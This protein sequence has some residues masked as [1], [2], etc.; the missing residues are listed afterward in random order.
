MT[1]IVDKA[2][3]AVTG[4]DLIGAIQVVTTPFTIT[5]LVTLLITWLIYFAGVLAF[6]FLVISGIIYITAGGDPEKVKRGQQGLVSAIIGIIIITL[7]FLILRAF[8]W[9]ALNGIT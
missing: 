2:F 9:I 1:P 5:N 7:S 6:V 8:G 3:S 4:A